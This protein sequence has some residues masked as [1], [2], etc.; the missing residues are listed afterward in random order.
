MPAFSATEFDKG[1]ADEETSVALAAPKGTSS[2][3]A[4]E[5][6]IQKFWNFID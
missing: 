3:I 4:T 2:K 6:P 1:T 5:K